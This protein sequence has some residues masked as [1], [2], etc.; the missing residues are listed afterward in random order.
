VRSRE[1]DRHVDAVVARVVHALA[2][3]KEQW[4]EAPPSPGPAPSTGIVE[5]LQAVVRARAD[6][7][8]VAPSMLAT[9]AE[10]QLL[11]QRHAAGDVSGLPIMQGW[12]RKMVG[13]DLCALLDGRAAVEIDA[14]QGRIRLRTPRGNDGAGG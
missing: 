4:P 8:H 14:T 3:P 2:L 6:E 10:L 5:L 11:T 9:N 7:V 12:R 13:N 1:L